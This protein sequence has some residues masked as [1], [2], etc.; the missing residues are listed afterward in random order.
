MRGKKRE[1]KKKNNRGSCPALLSIGKKKNRF[2]SIS[3]ATFYVCP[4]FP[5]SCDASASLSPRAREN[6]G[7]KARRRRELTVASFFSEGKSK[8]HGKK[9]K[10]KKTAEQSDSSLSRARACCRSSSLCIYAVGKR[11]STKAQCD[12]LRISFGA[13]EEKKKRS[14]PGK[15]KA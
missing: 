4:F 13:C 2:F 1:R 15:K 10:R 12:S 3:L 5:R 7:T 6:E 11:T 14:K 9:K 8:R